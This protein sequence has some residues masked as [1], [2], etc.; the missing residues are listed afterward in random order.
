MQNFTIEAD[1]A[2][3]QFITMNRRKIQLFQVYVMYDN[4]Q[5]RFHMQLNEETGEFYITDKVHCP[6]IYHKSEKI[7]SDAVKI[8]GAS[9]K[10]PT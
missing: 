3:F 4:R 5:A 8:Y 2:T 10:I 9:D 7:F 6:E 1:G